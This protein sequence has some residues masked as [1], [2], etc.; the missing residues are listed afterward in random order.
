[1]V[2]PV[3]YQN[4]PKEK[5]EEAIEVLSY[6]KVDP[7]PKAENPNKPILYVF[8]HGQTQDNA[9][10]IFSGW[11]DAELT[12]LGRHQAQIL[13]KKL[14]D[15]KLD[16]L[17]SSTQKR[18]YDTMK[19]AVSLNEH[20]KT[21]EIHKEPR[22]KERCYGDLQG[23]SKIKMYLEEPE[24]FQRYHRGYYDKATNGEN[25]DEVIKRVAN[26]LDEILPLMRET[27]INVAVSCHGN[28]M[29][30]FRKYFENL[31]EQEIC[32]VETPLAQDYAAY[33]IE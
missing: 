11:R 12:E 15:K 10:F 27:K 3:L 22:I 24:A 17:I 6:H 19:I 5:I 4:Y 2:D 16:M 26:F 31:S 30:G 28:S 13:A 25:L 14:A 9:D 32:Y 21:L 23:E 1:M 7:L 33:I 29:R 18:S 20:A 8:R